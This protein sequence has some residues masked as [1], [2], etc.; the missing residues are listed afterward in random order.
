MDVTPSRYHRVVLHD[1]LDTLR[2]RHPA[3]GLLASQNAPLVLHFLWHAFVETN[4][5]N[6]AAD[7]LMRQLDDELYALRE[8]HG[9]DAYPRA[10]QAY[11]DEWA[12]ARHGWL[13]KF[14]PAGSDVPHFDLTPVAQH[15]IDF[16]ENLNVGSFVGT[17]SRLNTILEL[18]RQLVVGSDADPHVRLADL[19]RRRDLIDAE[20]ARVEA[21]HV[22]VLD[23]AAQRDRYQQFARTARELLADFRQV[24]DNFRQL[25]RRLREQIAGWEG[26]KGELLDQIVAERHGI[27]DS[28]Q[29][30]S[31]RA[32]YDLLLSADRQTELASL[33]DRVHHDAVDIVE[34]DPR[35]A[36]AHFDWIDASER[37][38]RTV[39]QLSEQLRRFLDDQVWLENRRVFELIRG[40]EQ[41]ALRLRDA[42]PPPPSMEI[43]DTSVSV[44]LPVE[45]PLFRPSRTTDL[46]AV[47]IEH[48]VGEVDIGLLDAH[49]FVDRTALAERVH[50]ALG[51][52]SEARLV[53][54][55]AETP[56]EH[57]LAELVGYFTLDATEL[58]V[59]FDDDARDQLGWT[60]GGTVRVAEFPA[61][62]FSRTEAP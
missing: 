62:T 45:R 32:F 23:G 34:L 12:D 24:E 48:G 50:R 60:D 53:D 1:E 25:D 33:L 29:G 21:G 36:R 56:I 28:D 18:L 39:R 2:K 57:G 22:D 52:R 46:D 35:L 9:A 5:S 4:A 14:Y 6:I 61:V 3:W 44:G 7:T 26:S 11:L 16:V 31:F 54:V 49:A 40:I 15:A 43:D 38:Q 19:R 8:Q 20:I 41:K 37:T 47:T 10:P 17:E 51:A 27:A 55:V 59:S 42:P 30:R 13:R 58:H